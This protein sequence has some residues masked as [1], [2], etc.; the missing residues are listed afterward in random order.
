MIKPPKAQKNKKKVATNKVSTLNFELQKIYPK[1]EN[2]EKTFELYNQG[3]NLVLYGSAGAGKSYLSLFLGL[4]DLLHNS[5]YNKIVIIRSAVPSRD[6]GFLPGN[7]KEKMAVYEAPYRAIVSDLFGRDDAYE[8]LKQKDYI[9]FESSS[10]LRGMTYS[11]SLIFVDEIENFSYSELNTILSRLGDGSRIILAGDIKQCDFN[12]RRET[13]CMPEL[14]Q[15]AGEM[16]EEYF[17]VVEFTIED[18]VRSGFAKAYLQ[19]KEKLKL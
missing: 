7:E 1:T 8:I 3:K 12:S 2:Q 18:C 14:L 16:G 11:N 4:K 9:Q 6:I 15:I 5:Y 17:G 19:A 10:F 13:S